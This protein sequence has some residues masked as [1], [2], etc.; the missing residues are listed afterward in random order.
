[1]KTHYDVLGVP[2]SADHETVRAA[3]RKIVKS[4]HPDLHGNDDTAELRSKQINT[5]YA[6]LKDPERRARYDEHLR[7]RGTR[8]RL[9][10]ITVLVSAGLGSGTTLFVLNFLLKPDAVTPLAR[11]ST[12]T[13]ERANL[14]DDGMPAA[15]KGP[16]LLRHESTDAVAAENV[17]PS[18][19]SVPAEPA[20]EE[21]TASLPEPAQTPTAA[22]T[23]WLDVEKSGNADDI[24]VFIRQHGG[25][26]QAALAEK[27]L[28]PL[29]DAI[30]D[31][32]S[33]KALR[34]KATGSLL[35][36]VL[37][38]LG[39]LAAAKDDVAPTVPQQTSSATQAEPIPAAAAKTAADAHPPQSKRAATP[40]DGGAT[41]LASTDP[42]SAVHQALS[43]MTSG[44]YVMAT[45]ISRDSAPITHGNAKYYVY[46]AGFWAGK[47]DF[48]RAL[49]DYDAAILLD[50][51]N[52]AAFHGRGLLRWRRGEAELAL[53]DF[54]QA[55]RLSFTDPKIYLDR[56]QIW[57]ERG[58]YDRAIADFNQAIKLAPYL[59]NAYSY[60]GTALRRKR[61]F[62]S[63]I[64]DLDQAIRL[65]PDITD[66]YRNRDLARTGRDEPAEAV[67]E[68]SR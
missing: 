26:P 40:H 12:A 43:L 56:G 10:A 2:P 66:A 33:L 24:W 11:I 67:A 42:Q 20:P 54:D 45:P 29:I 39:K 49:T 48:D 4:Y 60:R 46:R 13:I 23:A 22:E 38:R 36:R 61:E 25:T 65:N 1:M 6:V 34:A 68:T 5:A 19:A 18:P 64:A 16:A 44:Q 8:V 28:E 51:A 53:A 63:A 50:G 9:F 31:I 15:A 32:E 58:R 59:A 17:E 21:H 62:Q 57:Y 41:R 7:R 35:A 3:Y 37:K 55:I 27:R 47:G 52:I 30:D 14:A